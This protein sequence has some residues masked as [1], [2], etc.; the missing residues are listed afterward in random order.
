MHP[1]LVPLCSLLETDART[2]DFS[3]KKLKLGL[4]VGVVKLY[5]GQVDTPS[6]SR[7]LMPF[8]LTLFLPLTS[9]AKFVTRLMLPHV[10]FGGTQR[11]KGEVSLLGSLG[12]N[13]VYQRT[14][15]ALVLGELKISM[16]L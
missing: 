10:D 16:M 3:K 5:L 6:S 9:L 7:W 14:K 13:C 1:T 11:R 15:V 8:N 12:T 4:R 2:F